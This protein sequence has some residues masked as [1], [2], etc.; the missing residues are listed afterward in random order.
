MHTTVASASVLVSVR[1]YH[2]SERQ[3]SSY[4]CYGAPPEIGTKILRSK[5]VMAQSA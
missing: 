4:D 2:I 5:P 3:A 1:V